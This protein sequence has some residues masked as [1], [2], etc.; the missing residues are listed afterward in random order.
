MTST[1]WSYLAVSTSAQAETLEDQ[2]RWAEQTALA[3]DWE[4]TRIF[5]GVSSGASGVRKLLAKLLA[6]LKATP[7]AERPH[8][9]LMI[10][11]D[12]LG[13]GDGLDVIA[14]IAQIRNLG[15]TIRTRDDG[16]LSLGSA[17]AAILP[18]IKSIVAGIENDVRRDKALATYAKRRAN[19]Q[20]VATHVPYGVQLVDGRA[21]PREPQ[22]SIVR[23]AY[24]LRLRDRGHHSIAREL[25][26]DAPPNILSDGSEKPVG[27]HHS[28]VRFM[29]RCRTYRDVVIPAEIWDR[30]QR[31]QTPAFRINEGT[32]YP[33]P[34]AGAI[35]CTCGH[36]LTVHP[37]ISGKHVY[38]SYVCRFISAHDGR[39][40][41]HRAQDVEDQFVLILERL[42]ASPEV[43][44][45]WQ[46]Y[47]R[48]KPL[49]ATAMRARLGQLDRSIDQSDRRKE[50]AWNMAAGGKFESEDLRDRLASLE[51]DR[52]RRVEQRD[53]LRQ[54][55]AVL[56][57]Q[58]TVRDDAQRIL[59]RASNTWSK[60][61]P[62]QKKRISQA[63]AAAL[64]G[65]T[66]TIDGQLRFVE[67]REN[68]LQT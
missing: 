54:Q 66:V 58:E 18:V 48:R 30:V 47:S 50:H 65:L 19:G 23:L 27:W 68:R 29:L 63:I 31:A 17:T 67:N 15:V 60:A 52:R 62:D 57:A 35:Q 22:A 56:E 1:V 46:E 36:R 2:A 61:A 38:R 51:A 64:G 5:S 24:D 44:K 21:V 7:K 16:D 37:S 12:R 34:L 4:I 14:A 28:S 33:W 43:A 42:V 49:D 25:F 8:R 3:N 40:I 53:T 9:V 11:L 59:A 55:V 45:A 32:R 20:H 41:R 39:D 13:R 10:R 6:E 26:R